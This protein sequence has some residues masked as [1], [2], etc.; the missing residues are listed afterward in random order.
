MAAL[1]A[2]VLTLAAAAPALDDPGAGAGTA[3]AASASGDSA[4]TSG[5]GASSAAAAPA[6]AAQIGGIPTIGTPTIGTPHIGAAPSAQAETSHGFPA[7]PVLP[8]LG[9]ALCGGAALVFA[10]R[11]QQATPKMLEIV[12]THGLGG[13]RSLIVA[14]I[15]GETVLLGSSEA[16]LSLLLARPGET[17]TQAQSEAHRPIAAASPPAPVAGALG[18]TWLGKLRLARSHEQG[19]E[20]KEPSFE[21]LLALD[22]AARSKSR[23]APATPLVEPALLRQPLDPLAESAEDQE[24]RRKL[25]QGRSGRIA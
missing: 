13:R 23:S 22:A 20:I 9:F 3:I 16:G 1:A 12:E 11:K 15:A 8:I 25:A 5:A 17:V 2:L 18:S 19:P 7:G 21:E 6:S 10:R 24:L 4:S 14:R